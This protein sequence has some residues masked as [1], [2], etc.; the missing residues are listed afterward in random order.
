MK[1]LS[2]F[3]VSP[4]AE[5][6]KIEEEQAMAKGYWVSAHRRAADPDKHAAYRPLAIAAITAAGGKFLAIGGQNQT[7]EYGLEQ[8]TVVIEFESYATALAAYE[9]EDYQRAL[10]ALDDG[11]ERDLRIVEGA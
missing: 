10:A 4:A 9:T 7:R 2:H 1:T 11:A 6:Q 8:R 3:V 5:A